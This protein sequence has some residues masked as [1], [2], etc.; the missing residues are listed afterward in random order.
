MPRSWV[1]PIPG[2][3]KVPTSVVDPWMAV[4]GNGAATLY[5]NELM[6]CK[7]PWRLPEG[8]PFLFIFYCFNNMTA[9]TW[10]QSSTVSRPLFRPWG[11]MF[12]A[13]GNFGHINGLGDF[14]EW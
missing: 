14:L 6:S 13:V 10:S 4:E 9:G 8:N 1:D 11:R 2:A 3:G 5:G 7:S 12:G